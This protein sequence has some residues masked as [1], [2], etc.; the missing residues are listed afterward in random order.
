MTEVVPMVGELYQA[1]NSIFRG[2]AAIEKGEVLL[3]ADIEELETAPAPWKRSIFF[4]SNGR[5]KNMMLT[6]FKALVRYSELV[7]VEA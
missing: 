2:S 7:K 1:K 3:V 6:D 5:V 4:L